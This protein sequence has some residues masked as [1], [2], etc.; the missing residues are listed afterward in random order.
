MAIVRWDVPSIN[1]SQTTGWGSTNWV[2]LDTPVQTY[3][4]TV[5]GYTHGAYALSLQRTSGSSAFG[6]Q[7]IVRVNYGD[8][9]DGND[10]DKY[11]GGDQYIIDLE[12]TTNTS[13]GVVVFRMYPLVMYFNIYVNGFSGYNTAGTQRATLCMWNESIVGV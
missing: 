2:G 8:G 5:T 13:T 1:N 9:T 11:V 7:V 10:Y 4:N 12:S 3:D 6:N